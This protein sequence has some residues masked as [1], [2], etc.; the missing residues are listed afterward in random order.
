MLEF[1]TNVNVTQAFC[2]NTDCVIF[3]KNYSKFIDLT[4]NKDIT[5]SIRSITLTGHLKLE[6]NFG[7]LSL[8]AAK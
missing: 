8:T 5:T 1:N 3:N 2:K 4:F 7:H 6:K